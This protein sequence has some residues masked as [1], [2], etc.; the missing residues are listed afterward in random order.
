MLTD[1]ADVQA[2]VI[3]LLF[4]WAGSWKVFVPRAWHLA[5][6]SALG[7]ILRSRPLTQVAHG[8]EGSGE[9]AIALLLLLPPERWWAMR[10]AS[11]FAV[12]FLVYLGVALRIVPEKICACM[13]G[14][15]RKVSLQSFARAGLVLAFT[16]LGWAARTFWIARIVASPW[17]VLIIG[18]EICALWLLSPEYGWAGPKITTRMW[19]RVRMTLNPTCNDITIDWQMADFNV[20]RTAQFQALPTQM[21]T[22]SDQWRDGCWGYIAYQIHYQGRP[23]TAVFAIPALFDMRDVSATVIDDADDAIVLALASVSG[24]VPKAGKSAGS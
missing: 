12:G 19:R 4:L 24:A 21:V 20:R 18:G 13:G 23:A 8:A 5:P 1:I 14:R 16:F 22:I 6:Q 17:T 15:V 7:S 10:L 9:M 3:G 2:V 11:V